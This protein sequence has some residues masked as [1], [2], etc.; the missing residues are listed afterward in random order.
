MSKKTTAFKLFLQLSSMH[1]FFLKNISEPLAEHGIGY[2]EFLILYYLKNAQAESKRRIDLADH[3]G[4]SVSAI[5]KLLMPMQKIGLVQKE[6]NPVK[7]RTSVV[8][9]TKA[10]KKACADAAVTI[11]SIT[12]ELTRSLCP[13]QLNAYERL[14]GDPG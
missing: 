6:I 8:T 14:F 10:G 2:T 9:I 7:V 1:T 5:T 4:I 11:E 13:E 3:L 12:S